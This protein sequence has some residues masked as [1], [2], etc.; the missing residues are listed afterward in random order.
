MGNC[1]CWLSEAGANGTVPLCL[2]ASSAP[3]LT[4]AVLL[5]SLLSAVNEAERILDALETL[6]EAEIFR[7]TVD[8]RIAVPVGATA[9]AVLPRAA[10]AV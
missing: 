10:C 2:P 6:V 7:K 4:G 8:D 5:Y 9:I 3:L 1:S